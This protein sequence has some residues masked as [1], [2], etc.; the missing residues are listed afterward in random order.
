M[1]SSLT[2]NLISI[3]ELITLVNSL[4]RTTAF[5]ASIQ[6]REMNIPSFLC[7]LF[8]AWTLQIITRFAVCSWIIALSRGCFGFGINNHYSLNFLQISGA[9]TAYKIC[10]SAFMPVIY[11]SHFIQTGV[12]RS[13]HQFQHFFQIF[14][15]LNKLHCT[16]YCKKYFSFLHFLSDVPSFLP[17]QIC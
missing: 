7:N 3:W 2:Q 13:L 15:V 1:H 4:T 8:S 12:G 11:I 14:Y 6:Y 17:K 9:L 10:C 5:C 16:A